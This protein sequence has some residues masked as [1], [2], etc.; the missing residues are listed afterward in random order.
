M[1]DKLRRVIICGR[2][3][4]AMVVETSLAQVPRVDVTRLDPGLPGVAERIAALSPDLVLIERGSG[5]GDLA[6]ALLG[7]G[8]PLLELDGE[9]KRATALI[10]QQL[11]A[12]GV[13]DLAQVIEHLVPARATRSDPVEKGESR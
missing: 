4:F 12:A 13:D 6:L 1:D 9:A 11:P 5:Q 8:I 7:M 10:G 2:S 3:I